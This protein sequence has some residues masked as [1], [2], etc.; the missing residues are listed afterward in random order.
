[1]LYITHKPSLVKSIL[2]GITLTLFAANKAQSDSNYP[3]KNMIY[4]SDS[5]D[6]ITNVNSLRDVSPNDW[7]YESLRSLIER[8]GCIVGYPD[9]IFK[10]GKSLS[11]WEFA[12][13]LNACLN[14]LERLIQQEAIAK[15]DIEK[16]KKLAED[17]K[18]E[19]AELGAKID[20]LDQRVSLLENHQ[21]STTTKLSGEV[22]FSL[23]AASQANNQAVFQDRV[24]L[25]LDTAFS[26]Q[27]VLHTR[28][29]GGNFVNFKSAVNLPDY[30][31]EVFSPT[32]TLAASN[33]AT[34][35]NGLAIDW[36]VYQGAINLNKD[37]K[38]DTYI[39]AVGGNWNDYIGTLSPY[40]QDGNGGTASL[41]SF[42]QQNPIYSIGG[43]SGIGLNLE[44]G[45]TES[46]LGPS[47]V[48]LGYF[49]GPYAEIPGQG[50]GLT[51]G[52]YA[53]LGQ[54]TANIANFI[55]LGFTY[56]NAYQEQGVPIFNVGNSG[57]TGAFV[58]TQLANGIVQGPNG[59]VLL[60]SNKV[61]N[62]FGVE[63]AITP[64][65]GISLNAFG[66]YTNVN[67][68]GNPGLPGA[69]IN[70]TGQIWTYG[71]GI[72]FTDLLKEG[73]VL[74]LFSGVQ[75]YFGNVSTSI[76]S[77]IQG[78]TTSVPIQVEVFYKYPVNDNFSITPG[79]IWL[80]NP[81]QTINSNPQIIGV[82]RGTFKF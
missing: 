37:L 42:T 58:G 50:S 39:G 44:I 77:T 14:S 9:Q 79:F 20:K 81:T 48:S 80:S 10:G 74:G 32:T 33:G 1:M 25:Q 23:A 24:R 30:Q 17:F 63:A 56:V 4:L 43:G 6:Q 61:T 70:G 18:G 64:F 82:L 62:S 2:L 36:L 41:S 69:G 59:T 65:K 19:L 60:D 67:F 45:S 73:S 51:S 40:F 12:A 8:Y 49:A 28:L 46:V 21:F 57:L 76:A 55:S 15:E 11:R 68:V 75:P 13:G 72:A 5:A 52:N 29:A 78:Y 16:I 66:T 22:I 7:A 54:F 31:G 53:L 34:T 35:N 27:D 26:G 71:G 38:L 47:S 3:N